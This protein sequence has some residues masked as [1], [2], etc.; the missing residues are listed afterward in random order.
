M[1]RPKRRLSLDDRA[2]GAAL[3]DRREIGR[4]L[5]TTFARTVGDVA[6]QGLGLW[7][8][9][10]ARVAE[11]DRLFGRALTVWVLNGTEARWV[12]VRAAHRRLLDSWLHGIREFELERR[13]E[14]GSPAYVLPADAVP[15]SD[16]AWAVVPTDELLDW[17][18]VAL[19][20]Q[21]SEEVTR[22]LA[23]ILGQDERP[24]STP[25]EEATSGAVYGALDDAHHA[26]LQQL[27]SR[28]EWD[29]PTFDR[30][31]RE[32]GVLASAAI[33]TINAVSF[34]A[35]GELVLVGNDPLE[36]NRDALERMELT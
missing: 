21:E 23:S 26:L 29:R 13:S 32:V 1:S 19:L 7:D 8:P 31:A 36:V 3:A 14:Q 25:R 22:L 24:R 17:D 4:E 33:E 11:P 20:E 28:A 12:E 27:R 34:D 30:F 5:C 9:I 10:W 16:A 15:R 18:R 2:R 35:T 6:P